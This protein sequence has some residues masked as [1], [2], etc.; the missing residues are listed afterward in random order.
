MSISL[1]GLKYDACLCAQVPRNFLESVALQDDQARC[2]LEGLL[3]L[4]TAFEISI[5]VGSG[6]Y[7]YNRPI[8]VMVLK[9]SDRLGA[10]SR[11]QGHEHIAVLSHIATA[12]NDPV[13]QLS[14]YPGIALGCH[15]ISGVIDV[16]QSGRNKTYLHLPGALHGAASPPTAA[17]SPV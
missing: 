7:N 16:R 17:A 3:G 15:A 12:N 13:T 4:M 6:Q 8:G 5:Q 9:S 2:Q 1:G 11:M 10:L 14:K